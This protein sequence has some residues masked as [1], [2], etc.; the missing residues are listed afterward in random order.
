MAVDCTNREVKR[1]MNNAMSPVMSNFADA[2]RGRI[3]IAAHAA[4]GYFHQRHYRAISDYSRF[5]FGSCTVINWGRLA[6]NSI[7]FVVSTATAVLIMSQRRE[8][9]PTRAALAITYSFLFPY[10]L[11][12]TS[13]LISM[14][15]TGATSLER[16][17]QFKRLPQEPEW[18]QDTD[19]EHWPSQGA[20]EFREVQLRYR[21]DLPLAVKGASFVIAP[22]EQIGVVGRTGAGKS[23]L[24]VLLFR[25]NEAS[26]GHILLDGLD[27]ATVGLRKLRRA[28]AVI[29]QEPLRLRGDV[30]HNLDP[31]GHF[32]P[33]VLAQTIVD[34]GLVQV[35]GESP[36]AVLAT[37]V[38]A[39]SVGEAQLLSLARALLRR[40][41]VKIVVMDEAT[42]AIDPETD[43]QVQRVLASQLAS[44][45]RI[46]IAHRLH[47]VIS[48]KILVMADG[49]VAQ[50]GYA[51]ELAQDEAGQFAKMLSAMGSEA[52]CKMMATLQ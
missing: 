33:S 37:Q 29:P 8:Y 42:S 2:M 38:D 23:S 13:F 32:E 30:S 31:F 17:L 41:E 9:D 22:G 16:L 49:G 45:T 48:H 7:S 14:C 19:P 35:R 34:V 5:N 3:V 15:L 24:L 20:I 36:D 26:G 12:L 21:P 40:S 1:M 28:M 25:L 47:T 50:F 43:A 10:F 51:K 46:T 44:Q 27:I 52:S 4:Q 39:M 11:A 18:H 6:S